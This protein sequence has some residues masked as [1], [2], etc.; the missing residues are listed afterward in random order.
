MLHNA[1]QK[2]SIWAKVILYAGIALSVIA[3]FIIIWY[4]AQAPMLR[5]TYYHMG[6]IY[7]SGSTHGGMAI[8]GG[9]LV[10]IFGSLFSW[11]CALLM[12]AFGELT[13]DT[14]AIREQLEDV[15]YEDENDEPVYTQ[16]AESVYTSPAEPAPEASA[17][18]APDP[19]KPSQE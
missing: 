15:F 19:E 4:G 8:I 6:T 10:M 18:P 3:G 17:E 2:I 9:F 5:Y 12:T 1:S 14:R 16:A 11:L 13:S 7:Q